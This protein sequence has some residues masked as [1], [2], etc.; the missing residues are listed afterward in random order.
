MAISLGSVI[1]FAEPLQ[2][3]PDPG[4]FAVTSKI[5][6]KEW[7]MM[8]GQVKVWFITPSSLS[9]MEASQ[10]LRRNGYC[11]QSE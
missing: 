2:R 11:M 4:D 6:R 9:G 10:A 5:L 7:N 8:T 1:G 3:V